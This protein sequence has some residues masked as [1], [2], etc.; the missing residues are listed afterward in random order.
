MTIAEMK[1]SCEQAP[2]PQK[3]IKILAQLHDL[4]EADVKRIIAMEEDNEPKLSFMDLLEDEL[5]KVEMRLRELE[6]ELPRLEEKY[7]RIVAA[8]DLIGELGL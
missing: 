8:I 2:N 5:E 7:R 1:R 3:Q 4:S 6:E